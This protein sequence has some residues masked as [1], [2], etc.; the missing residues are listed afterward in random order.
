MEEIAVELLGSQYWV[1]LLWLRIKFEDGLFPCDDKKY[2]WDG[3]HCNVNGYPMV[4][5]YLLGRLIE[6][7]SSHLEVDFNG[8]I[9]CDDE[10]IG[11]E[12]EPVYGWIWAGSYP[13]MS[14]TLNV[15]LMILFILVNIKLFVI[16][17]YGIVVSTGMNMNYVMIDAFERN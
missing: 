17:G 12:F 1:F 2:L 3:S 10:V 11:C 16:C 9:D 15:E 6:V 14:G 4:Y 13:V 5:L 7:L 8:L